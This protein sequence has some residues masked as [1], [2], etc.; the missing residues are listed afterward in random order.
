MPPARAVLSRSGGL[1]VWSALGA[2]PAMTSPES[3][4]A[5]R[6]P[7]TP[8][9]TAPPPRRPRL[10]AATWLLRRVLQPGLRSPVRRGGPARSR[11]AL[12]RRT[13]VGRRAVGR[14]KRTRVHE[15]ERRRRVDLR[16]RV[17]APR[18]EE[19]REGIVRHPS[20]RQVDGRQRQQ[21]TVVALCLARSIR[22]RERAEMAE[23]PRVNRRADATVARA[24]GSAGG[25][26][27]WG[28]R[29]PRGCFRGE[30]RRGA[31]PACTHEV[32]ACANRPKKGAQGGNGERPAARRELQGVAGPDQRPGADRLTTVTRCTRTSGPS[33][34]RASPAR[35]LRPWS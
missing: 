6:A 13:L 22:V 28:N 8:R 17:L 30:R 11:R 14:S 34:S 19:T 29:G 15:R 20:R 18:A 24:P 9:C 25:A 32:P 23:D 12:P 33:R 16:F 4:R 7:T 5:R 2:A 35:R 21:A 31:T 3:G 27:S 26:P 10:R 1:A